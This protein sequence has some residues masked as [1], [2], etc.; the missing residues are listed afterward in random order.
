MRCGVGL[1]GLSSEWFEKSVLF[2][3]FNNRFD[4]VL[5]NFL[6]TYVRLTEGDCDP[7]D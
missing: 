5:L 2:E 6:T 1:V 4:S 7:G 3:L